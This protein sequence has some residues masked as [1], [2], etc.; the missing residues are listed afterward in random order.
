MLLVLKD[1]NELWAVPPI[2]PHNKVEP[3]CQLKGSP[4]LSTQQS[5][6]FA[7]CRKIGEKSSVKSKAD[8]PLVAHVKSSSVGFFPPPSHGFCSSASQPLTTSPI[9][10]R[11]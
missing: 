3:S 4:A 1:P 7:A 6:L 11:N 8:W 10:L 9:N 2:L 5:P